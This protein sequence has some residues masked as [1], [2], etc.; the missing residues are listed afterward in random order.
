M[1]PDGSSTG[2][3]ITRALRV[4]DAVAAAGDGVTAKAIARRLSCPLP[5]V[6]RALGTLVEEG[7]L[8]RFH[9]RRGYGLGYRIGELHR[10]LTEQVR[11]ASAV[12]AVLRDVHASLGA[13]CHLL[14]FREID[15]VVAAVDHCAE[16]PCPDGLDVGEPVPAHALAAG[17]VLLAQLRPARVSELLVHAGAGP[18]TSRTMVERRALDRELLRVRSAGVA[19]EV[20]EYRPGAAGVAA[21]VVGPGGAVRA[22]IGVSVSRAEFAARRWEL[23]VAVRAAAA[24]VARAD[25]DDPRAAGQL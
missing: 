23:E 19:V 15:I 16:H 1:A 18:I 4:V 17:K 11:P 7:Y 24:Q 2:S 21:P 3:S 9:D 8:V 6:Y 25:H 5:T 14:V 22:A 10:S 20:E 13:A 12:R